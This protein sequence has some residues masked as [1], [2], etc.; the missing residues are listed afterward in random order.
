MIRVTVWYEYV[1][2]SGE[3]RE[4]FLPKGVPS[5][6]IAGFQEFV[7][8]SAEKIHEVYSLGVMGTVADYLG[9]CPDMEVTSVNMYMPEFGLPDELLE[10]T[11]VL[12]WWAHIAHDAIPDRLVAKIKE[13]VHK[14]MGFIPLHSAHKSRPFTELLG[15]TGTLKW[16]EGDFCRVW[17]TAPIHPIAEGIP[18]SIELS[19]EEMY[20]EYFDVPK[21]DDVVFLS[22]YRGGEV[23][24]SGCTWTRGYG[25]IF[26]FQPGHETSP[27]YHNPW[28]LKVIEN[29]VRWAAPRVWRQDDFDCPNVLE[30]PESKYMLSVR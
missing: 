18:E 20:G 23:F 6:H 24:R 26:Y 7:K 10:R 1:Q 15:T 21:P 27:S 2:E 4:E 9:K 30:S 22:W 11:D 3:L 29:G 13:R 17:N 8:R 14:G 5:E 16:R 12:V 28:I 25:R 19:E